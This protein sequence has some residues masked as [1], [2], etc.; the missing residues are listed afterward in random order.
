AHGAARRRDEGVGPRRADVRPRQRGALRDRRAQGVGLGA[1]HPRPGGRHP[2][3]RPLGGR[4]HDHGAG[5]GPL[6]H[7]RPLG[8]GDDRRGDA[9]RAGAPHRRREGEAAGR[10]P[11]GDPHHHPAQGQRGRPRR[12]AGRGARRAGRAPGGVHRPGAVRGAARRQHER[13]EAALPR[14]A[15]AAHHGR[16]ARPRRRGADARQ[17]L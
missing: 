4:G 12:P 1:A 16:R 8:R 11:G 3:G 10:A 14:A 7:P 17:P 15:P 13:G 2:Q 9:D 5:L 6:G